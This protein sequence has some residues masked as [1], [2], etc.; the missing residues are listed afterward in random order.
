M[1][2]KQLCAHFI[3]LQNIYSVRFLK[4]MTLGS[5]LETCLLI[6]QKL[7]KINIFLFL[8]F[9]PIHNIIL[10]F[11]QKFQVCIFFVKEIIACVIKIFC[12]CDKI[13]SKIL[14]K[15]CLLHLKLEMV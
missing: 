1:Q 14:S 5:F 2:N 7:P 13:A 4:I 8:I 11:Q 3:R 12:C 15:P 10:R 6:W 9:A